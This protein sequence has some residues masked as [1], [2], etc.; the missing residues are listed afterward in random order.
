M[1]TAPPKSA[2]AREV[3]RMVAP[4]LNEM[5][6]KVVY[7]DVRARVTAGRIAAQVFEEVK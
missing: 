5:T 4:R 7:G 1:S 6:E 3:V 2:A